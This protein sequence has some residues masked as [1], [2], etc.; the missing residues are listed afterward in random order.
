MG[1][2]SRT[3]EK[4]TDT[5]VCGFLDIKGGFHKLKSLRDETDYLLCK[6]NIRKARE[7]ELFDN[8]ETWISSR[9]AG[10][11]HYDALQGLKV[12]KDILYDSE[13]LSY[14]VEKYLKYEEQ[15]KDLNKKYG[16]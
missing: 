2:F 6:Q 1:L 7:K 10:R 3:K 8:V 4:D 15:I 13:G 14:I 12:I 16:K 11:S 5:E 9:L